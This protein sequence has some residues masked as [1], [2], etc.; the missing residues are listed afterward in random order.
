MTPTEE[1]LERLLKVVGELGSDGL[2]HGAFVM[3]RE[4][5]ASQLREALAEPTDPAWHDRPT[6]PGLWVCTLRDKRRGWA[7]VKLDAEDLASG[8][9][10][11]TSRVYGPIPEDGGE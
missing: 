11:F 3:E 7:A 10:R 1:Q 8:A 6:G 5:L 4:A 2:W 9:P